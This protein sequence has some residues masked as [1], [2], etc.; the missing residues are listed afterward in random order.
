MPSLTRWKDGAASL[1]VYLPTKVDYG[2]PPTLISGGLQIL[3]NA[4]QE[5]VDLRSCVERVSEPDRFVPRVGIGGGHYTPQANAAVAACF[6]PTVRG[7][8]RP[9][10][11]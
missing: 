6:G 4:K 10:T 5:H 3:K 7:L 8:V 9:A 11:K 1:L 2:T